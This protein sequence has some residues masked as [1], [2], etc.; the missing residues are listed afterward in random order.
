MFT[1]FMN[2]T[3]AAIRRFVTYWLPSLI[4]LNAKKY[5]PSPVC[6][7]VSFG[8]SLGNLEKYLKNNNIGHS[9]IQIPVGFVKVLLV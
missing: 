3:K 6:G 7:A 2:H 4:G 9:V 1:F 8:L 5:I